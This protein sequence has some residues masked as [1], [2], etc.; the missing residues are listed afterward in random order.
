MTDRV[1]MDCICIGLFSFQLFNV[2]VVRVQA[3]T[4]DMVSW[5]WSGLSYSS[6][7]VPHANVA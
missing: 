2:D 3:G 7:E 1:D 6:L 5:S 4:V